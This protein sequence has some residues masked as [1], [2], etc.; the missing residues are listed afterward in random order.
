MARPPHRRRVGWMPGCRYFNPQ[1]TPVPGAGGI[2]I[3][4]DEL[5]AIRLAD[6]EGMYQE[7]AAKRMKVS[8]PTFARII[9]SAR[10]KVAR[11]LVEGRALSLEGGNIVMTATRKFRCS[12]CGHT[13]ELPFGTARLATCPQCSSRN[14][15]RA[16]EDRGR[17]RRGGGRGRHGFGQAGS[18]GGPKRA[19]L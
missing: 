16:A 8:R 15:H 5:E 3:G 14:L 13:W 7:E 2:V 1:G 6:L 10:R 12:D 18:A 17:A 11:A 19:P 4:L 9:E